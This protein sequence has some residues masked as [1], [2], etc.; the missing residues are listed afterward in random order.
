MLEVEAVH[1][2]E[3][4]TSAAGELRSK[5][6]GSG[7]SQRLLQ[8]VA[9]CLGLLCPPQESSLLDFEMKKPKNPNLVGKKG[10]TKRDAVR[11]STAEK[12]QSN[13]FSF[14]T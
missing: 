3:L 7:T 12:I 9:C 11:L 5:G 6:T 14:F 13:P 10:L 8:K 2:Q 4:S 1:V